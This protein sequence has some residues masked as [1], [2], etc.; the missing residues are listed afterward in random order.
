MSQSLLA[1]VLYLVCNLTQE[2]GLETIL[3]A[4]FSLKHAVNIQEE[5]LEK[6]KELA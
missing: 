1:D 6:A 4:A 2:A 5:A 3:S